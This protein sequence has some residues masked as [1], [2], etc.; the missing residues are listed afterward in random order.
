MHTLFSLV[1]LSCMVAPIRDFG[2]KFF[3]SSLNTHSQ[4][5][6]YLPTVSSSINIGIDIPTGNISDNYDEIKGKKPLYLKY[7][8]L[9][10]LFVL[11]QVLCYVP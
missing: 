9:G 6:F 11:N 8:I 7:S 2:N 4:Q 3:S 1:L 5:T 10:H